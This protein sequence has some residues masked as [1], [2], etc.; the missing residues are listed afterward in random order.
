MIYDLAASAISIPVN[1]DHSVQ[2]LALMGFM[3]SDFDWRF[4][5]SIGDF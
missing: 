1:H 5:I 4:A 2:T 3:I